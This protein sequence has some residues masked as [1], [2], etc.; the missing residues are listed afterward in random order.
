M[1]KFIFI[2]TNYHFIILF[3]GNAI[4]FFSGM[5]FSKLFSV[6][7]VN[8]WLSVVHWFIELVSFCLQ[9]CSLELELEINNYFYVVSFDDIGNPEE[10][11][12]VRNKN[13]TGCLEM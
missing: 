8:V 11:S 10:Y 12:L 6:V 5:V 7:L 4:L 1:A 9:E 3:K 13:V 2:I